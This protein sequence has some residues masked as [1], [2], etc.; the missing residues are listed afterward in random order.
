[1]YRTTQGT[2]QEVVQTLYL[3]YSRVEGSRPSDIA[4]TLRSLVKR[5][6][7][8]INTQRPSCRSRNASSRQLRKVLVPIIAILKQQLPARRPTPQLHTLIHSCDNKLN[9]NSSSSNKG[10]EVTQAI[11]C[12]DPAL[13]KVITTTDLHHQ[14]HSSELAPSL[15]MRT[16]LLQLV[17]NSKALRITGRRPPLAHC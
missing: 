7:S 1:M 12:A 2:Q 4:L 13:D 10:Q 17:N 6:N 3:R 5:I 8:P 15:G 11:S 16:V 9:N 14:H